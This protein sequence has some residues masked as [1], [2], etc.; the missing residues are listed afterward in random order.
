MYHHDLRV[1]TENVRRLGLVI[2]MGPVGYSYPM[3]RRWFTTHFLRPG[4]D[5]AR[6]DEIIPVPLSLWNEVDDTFLVADQAI[7]AELAP[8][9]GL[10]PEELCE[11]VQRRTDCLRELSQ[12]SAA[13][14]TRMYDAIQRLR[15]REQK[16]RHS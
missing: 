14:P 12:D 9:V 6:P 4:V 3:R 10:A 2:N 7:L 1:A 5:A 16:R 8:W 13:D 11:A 15:K